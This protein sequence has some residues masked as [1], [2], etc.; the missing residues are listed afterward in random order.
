MLIRNP[1][2]PV[3]TCLARDEGSPP[4]FEEGAGPRLGTGAGDGNGDGRRSGSKGI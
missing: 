4:G 1:S 3:Y 2:V